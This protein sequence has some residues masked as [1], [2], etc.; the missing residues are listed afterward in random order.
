MNS[1]TYTPSGTTRKVLFSPRAHG[2][3]DRQPPA[4]VLAALVSGAMR[5]LFYERVTKE[6]RRSAVASL[7]LN[8]A[9]GS[10]VQAALRLDDR[11]YRLNAVL[12]LF[13]D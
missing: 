6:A 7:R 2:S 11:P 8:A 13:G 10:A 4:V 3:P 12:H 9:D 1:D 5:L